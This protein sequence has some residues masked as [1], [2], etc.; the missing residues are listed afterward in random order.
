[1]F[2]IITQIGQTACKCVFERTYSRGYDLNNSYSPWNKIK[3]CKGCKIR[4][5]KYIFSIMPAP[6]KRRYVAHHLYISKVGYTS[7][8]KEVD[9]SINRDQSEFLIACGFDLKKITKFFKPT[10]CSG[11]A[12]ATF[13][14]TNICS[15]NY[16]YN[17]TQE[18]SFGIMKYILSDYKDILP[19]N[20]CCQSFVSFI[21]M[22]FIPSMAKALSKGR[23]CID[24]IGTHDGC[25]YYALNL[26][27]NIMIEEDTYIDK[28]NY[29]DRFINRGCKIGK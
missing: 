17:Y 18:E 11:H 14:I 24:P 12:V 3:S 22:G 6:P 9:K 20:N 27:D 10:Y 2:G 26:I 16:S 28:I 15:K 29:W 13:I 7:Q 23:C 8:Y 25:E 19:C 1:M 21:E 4:K 5:S